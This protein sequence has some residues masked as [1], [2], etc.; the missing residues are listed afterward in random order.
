[1]PKI[2][3]PTVREH[4]AAQRDLILDAVGEIVAEYGAS[5]LELAQVARRV[6]LART[7]LYRYGRNRDDLV[8]AWLD[9]EF[10]PVFDQV[11]TALAGPGTPFER[12]M[13]WLDVQVAFAGQPQHEAANRIM[14]DFAAL[15]PSVRTAMEAQ[16][17]Q[18]HQA[19]GKVVGEALTDQPD[20]DPAL[21]AELL[22]AIAT[23][24]IGCVVAHGGPA[25]KSEAAI[26]FAA[27]LGEPQRT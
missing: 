12:L 13:A 16:H 7:S 22:S 25:A 6:G 4:H 5:Q 23:A 20:R 8:A 2:S 15:P 3:A 9:R 11:G 27:L 10:G 18:L 17:S 1:M 14:A 21:V 19:V 24:T 26:A